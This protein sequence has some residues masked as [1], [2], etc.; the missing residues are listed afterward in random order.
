MHVSHPRGMTCAE[1]VEKMCV[2]R[3][4]HCRRDPH[5]VETQVKRLGFQAKRQ[6]ARTHGF[7]QWLGRFMIAVGP[8][9]HVSL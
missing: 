9:G 4:R 3:G 2:S 1:P 7:G 8:R 6:L 5:A